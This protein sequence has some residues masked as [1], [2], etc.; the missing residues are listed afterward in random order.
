[1]AG[2]KQCVSMICP[3]D[4]GVQNKAGHDKFLGNLKG[5]QD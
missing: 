3:N 5:D 2:H 4:S 1:M